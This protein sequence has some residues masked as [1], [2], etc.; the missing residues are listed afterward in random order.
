M[1]SLKVRKFEVYSIIS[2]EFLTQ[3]F[4]GLLFSCPSLF[5]LEAGVAHLFLSPELQIPA[6]WL[7]S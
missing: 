2:G 1:F 3:A 6:R 4:S 5:Y 7:T